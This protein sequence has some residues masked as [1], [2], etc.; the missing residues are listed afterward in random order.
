M[1]MTAC[2]IIQA[3]LGSP[4][5]IIGINPPAM[6]VTAVLCMLP[7]IVSVTRFLGSLFVFFD[8]LADSMVRS[9]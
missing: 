2:F 3:K 7:K 8:I 9:A 1:G 6:K 5:G 4:L